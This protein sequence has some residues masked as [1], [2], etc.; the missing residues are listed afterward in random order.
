MYS[1]AL[2]AHQI[3]GVLAEC[4]ALQALIKAK[5]NGISSG[6]NSSPP[7]PTGRSC[8]TANDN[9]KMILRLDV[10]TYVDT[11]SNPAAL[12]PPFSS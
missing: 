2:F 9:A 4:K 7:L 5:P 11:A 10:V 8:K 12:G 3:L 6:I 1:I